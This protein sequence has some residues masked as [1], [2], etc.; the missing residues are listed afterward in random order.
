MYS[1]YKYYGFFEK[2]LSV[3]YRV[4]IAETNERT[5]F[6]MYHTTKGE[7]TSVGFQCYSLRHN[8][9]ELVMKYAINF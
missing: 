6:C 2:K 8:Y 5:E 4:F 3:Q 9:V 7:R 1:C